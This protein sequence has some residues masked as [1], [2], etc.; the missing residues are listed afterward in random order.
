MDD[1][2]VADRIWAGRTWR[3][4]MLRSLLEAGARLALG[5]DAPVAP[6]DPWIAIAAA[7]F[8]TRDD[9][10]PWH[11]EQ[12]IT[13][14]QALAAS[15]DLR[16]DGRLQPQAGDRADLVIVDSDPCSADR[17]ALRH[18]PVSATILDGR[19]TYRDI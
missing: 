2:D 5:S 15:V 14:R 7:V 18:L 4:F 19:F 6:L 1:R 10:P 11:P 13:I 3:A 16:L 8:R 9:R 17:D 12:R